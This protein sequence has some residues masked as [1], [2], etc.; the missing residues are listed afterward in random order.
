[1]H[2]QGMGNNDA[3]GSP[4]GHP[5]T[6]KYCGIPIGMAAFFPSYA[7]AAAGSPIYNGARN[8]SMHRKS[9]K[10]ENARQAP[11]SLIG[12][13]LSATLETQPPSSR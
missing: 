12:R 2:I 13:I 5:G 8:H 7:L 9:K 1:M 3:S 11:E 6:S 4:R 10:A